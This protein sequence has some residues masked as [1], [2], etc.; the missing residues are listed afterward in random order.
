VPVTVLTPITAT[1]LTEAQLQRIS[2]NARQAIAP[3]SAHWVHLDQP[4][5][6]LGAIRDML[7]RI[8]QRQTQAVC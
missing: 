3:A 5:L 6:V 4:E 1:P 7:T 8:M 2:S